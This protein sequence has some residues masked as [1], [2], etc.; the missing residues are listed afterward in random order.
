MAKVEKLILAFLTNGRYMTDFL[1]LSY[2]KKSFGRCSSRFFLYFRK[3][4]AFT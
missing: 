4:F 1:Q 3:V 2:Y